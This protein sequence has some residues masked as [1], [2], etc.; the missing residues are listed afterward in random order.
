MN[1]KE[2]NPELP[3]IHS[4]MESCMRK[5]GAITKDSK[6][7]AQSKGQK[8]QYVYRSVD[9]VYN[10]LQPAMVDAGITVVPQ[11]L[12]YNRIPKDPNTGNYMNTAILKMAFRWTAA[13]GSYVETIVVNE[14]QDSGDKAFSKA[15]AN[16]FKYACFT[17][18]VIPTQEMDTFDP[19]HYRPEIE[20]DAIAEKAQEKK[21][22]KEKLADKRKEEQQKSPE[23]K[24]QDFDKQS[25]INMAASKVGYPQGLRTKEEKLEF[26]C[27][28]AEAIKQG[29]AVD[30]KTGEMSPEELQQ[31]MRA[32][33]EMFGKAE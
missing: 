26:G 1:E 2:R 17:T 12:E 30:K 11:V 14:G 9:A 27:M 13:D 3:M 5:I 19:D 15:M 20:N 32:V 21:T 6:M 24:K 33:V 4:C 16:C 22:L 7:D 23:P 10:A 8:I 28:V 18:F 29:K 25:C 31:C